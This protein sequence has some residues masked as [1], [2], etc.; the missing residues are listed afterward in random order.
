MASASLDFV[1]A[2]PPGM[3]G[4]G[5]ACKGSTSQ[6]VSCG[7]DGLLV[8]HNA[9]DLSDKITKSFQAEVVACHTLAVSPEQNSFAVGD[10]GHFVRVIRQHSLQD[11]CY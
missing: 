3:G 4:I 7:Q 1:P 2:H 10:Q 8:I 6:I 11:S 9:D 5:H